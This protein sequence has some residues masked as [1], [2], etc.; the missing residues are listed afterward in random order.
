MA[1]SYDLHF[2]ESCKTK[3]ADGAIAHT[4]SD[5]REPSETTRAHEVTAM[6]YYC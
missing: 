2:M 6:A 4:A 3:T 1:Y 5:V